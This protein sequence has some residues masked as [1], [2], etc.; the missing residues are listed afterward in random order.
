MSND[1]VIYPVDWYHPK[2]GPITDDVSVTGLLGIISSEYLI[3]FAPSK[4]T[5]YS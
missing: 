5:A 3:T 2:K 1:L 4:C